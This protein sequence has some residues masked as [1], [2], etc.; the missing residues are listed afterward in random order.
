M[1]AIASA[2]DTDTPLLVE[3]ALELGSGIRRW[4]RRARWEARRH[5][6][7]RGRGMSPVSDATRAAKLE[8]VISSFDHYLQARDRLIGS[9][10]P[11]TGDHCAPSP[12]SPG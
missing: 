12:T 8:A 6:G 2:P 9:Y 3:L 11:N 5:R 4:N 1:V 10:T 7:S